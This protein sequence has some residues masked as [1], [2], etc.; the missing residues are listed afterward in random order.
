MVPFFN[1]KASLLLLRTQFVSVPMMYETQG[2]GLQAELHVIHPVEAVNVPS[3]GCHLKWIL[4]G[5]QREYG[6]HVS[7]DV[8]LAGAHT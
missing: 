3:G 7:T 4:L 6:N 1:S 5:L 8:N 2:Q